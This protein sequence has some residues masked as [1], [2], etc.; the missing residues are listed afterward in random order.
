MSEGVE[1]VVSRRGQTHGGKAVWA[2]ECAGL[3][4]FVSETGD[5][6]RAAVV[7]LLR[8]VANEYE[9]HERRSLP[10]AIR[11]VPGRR[12]AIHVAA[13]TLENMAGGQDYRLVISVIRRPVA[14]WGDE[15]VRVY[16]YT[17][18]RW[19]MVTAALGRARGA[20]AGGQGEDG[21]DALG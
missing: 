18:R 1:I 19:W 14:H 15:T 17:D 9:R 10:E 21:Q 2:A 16:R 13:K 8:R 11:I 4:P 7:R 6:P 5:T 20:T 3:L 12:R